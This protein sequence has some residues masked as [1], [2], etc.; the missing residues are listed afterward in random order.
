MVSPFMSFATG[1]LQA[2]DKNID[3]Y[4]A[5]KAAEE[6]RADVTAQRM[7]ELKFERETKLEAQ[8][9][10]ARGAVDAA[11]ARIGAAQANKFTT[12][13]AFK[14]AKEA[15]DKQRVNATLAAL[16]ANP[17]EAARLLNSRDPDEAR[18]FK[19]HLMQTYQ[20][21]VSAFSRSKLPGDTTVPP[22]ILFTGYFNNI[23]SG[24]GLAPVRGFF[25]ELQDGNYGQANNFGPNVGAVQKIAGQTIPLVDTPVVAKAIEAANKAHFSSIGRTRPDQITWLSDNIGAGYK[26]ELGAYQEYNKF[27]SA[28]DS[29]LVKMIGMKQTPSAQLVEQA[30][31]FLYNPEHG[32]VDQEGNITDDFIKLVEIYGRQDEEISPVAPGSIRTERAKYRTYESFLATTAGKNAAKIVDGKVENIGL[33]K[34]ALTNVDRLLAVTQEAGTGSTT[35]NRLLQL[36]EGVPAVVDEALEIVGNALGEG[37]LS[38]R[39]GTTGKSAY[40]ILED[41]KKEHD[42][43]IKGNNQRAIAAAKVTMLETALAYQLT[44]ILQ[45]G[46]GGRTISDTDVKKTLDMMTGTYTSKEMKIAK[47]QEIKK[48]IIAHQNE[49][50]LYN[51]LQKGGANSGLY[52]TVLKSSRLVNNYTKDNFAQK[53]RKAAG[54]RPPS[55]DPEKNIGLIKPT[56]SIKP[57]A[58]TIKALSGVNYAGEERTMQLLRDDRISGKR[59]IPV[60]LDSEE[61]GEKEFLMIPELHI[62]WINAYKRYRKEGFSDERISGLNN[63][64]R[65]KLELMQKSRHGI[66]LQTN[67]VFE[68]EFSPDGT[69]NRKIKTPGPGA[70]LDINTGAAKLFGGSALA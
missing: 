46:T 51:L 59:L 58:N 65:L 30:N 10:S 70:S 6:E 69:V 16:A 15:D 49:A 2:V 64:Q 44:S 60:S 19:R 57:L 31:T 52:Y 66:D 41:A 33:T 54:T 9:I 38:K 48:M 55:E 40:G 37:R 47:L 4:R 23:L 45:G 18:A 5:E 62:K 17:Q 8:R 50:K 24:K 14:F 43:A 27:Y 26:E 29:A 68:L 61:T 20:D 63:I 32:F 7:K 28:A 1:A 36:V 25:Q 3:R 12:I 39:I 56:S 35:T 67:E 34:K 42:K 22:Q 13:G 11:K 53:I 21:G